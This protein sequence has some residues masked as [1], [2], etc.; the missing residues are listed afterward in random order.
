MAAKKVPVIMQM[1]ATECGAACLCMILAYYGRWEPLEKVRVEC[2]VSRDGSKASKLLKAARAYGMDAHGFT[3]SLAGIQK[4][5]SFPCILFWNFNH[6]VVLNG[7]RGKWAY[8]NDPARGTVR[9]SME[10][11]DRAFTGVVLTMEPTEDFKR[12]GSQKSTLTFV[13]KRLRG[14]GAPILFVAIASV[15][16]TITDLIS[17]SLSSTFM[18]NVLTGESPGW[19]M[20][21]LAIMCAAIIIQ[22]AV[23]MARAIYLNRIRGK[24]AVVSSSRFIWHLLHLPVGFYAQRMVGD[25]QQRQ[26]S[27][28]EIASTLMEQLAPSLLNALLLVLYLVVML[29]YSW[30]LTLVGITTVFVNSFLANYISKQRINVTRQQ[31]RDAGMFYGVTIAGIESIETIKASGAEDGYFER[32]SGYQALVNDANVRFAKTNLYLGA[33][34]ALLTELANL[35]VLLL[36]TYLIMQDQ[37]SAGSLLAFQ[38]FLTSFMGPVQELIGLGQ[39]VQEMRTSME[40]VQDVLDY[41]ADVFEGREET[42][43]TTTYRKLRGTVELDHVSFGYS[44]LDPP[45]IEN[46]SLSLQPGQWVALVGTSGSGKSTIAKLISGLYEP[47][48][49]VV[50]FDGMPISEISKDQLRGSLAVVDQEVVSFEDTVATNIRLWDGSIEDFE[51]IMAARDADIHSDIM[52]RDEGYRER[53]I[54]G[55]RN[56]SGGQLQRLEIARVLAQEPTV[57][58]LDEATS[59]LDAKTEGHVID[60]IRRRDITCIVVA[61]R[62]STIR[63]CDE[64]IVLDEGKVVERGT[65]EELMAIDGAYAELVRS[66]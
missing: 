22:A 53:L 54:S 28:E 8:L 49:G 65:H 63:D 25:L 41:P 35:A 1:E 59:A 34:P 50:R 10:E 40:R 20:P 14:M 21:I 19:L 45:L 55:G 30:K 5:S 2:G 32:W 47:W 61:H 23:D 62:L 48:A 29:Q 38:G 27:N 12:G 51:V 44:P 11:F 42:D 7:F 66:N 57:I 60:A 13:R 31:M 36:G 3:I 4:K 24:F 9:V 52:A 33:L 37:F 17:T 39:Q 58:I 16:V 56:F 64:I 15:I 46:F 43:A 26:E 6:F 18:D